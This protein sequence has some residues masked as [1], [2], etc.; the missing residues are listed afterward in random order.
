MNSVV[1]QKRSAVFNSVFYSIQLLL[2]WKLQGDEMS[3]QVIA[4][5]LFLVFIHWP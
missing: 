4:Q 1:D 5:L 3:F 2:K